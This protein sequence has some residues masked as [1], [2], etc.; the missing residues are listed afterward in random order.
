[1]IEAFLGALHADPWTAAQIDLPE[2]NQDASKTIETSI[3]ELRSCA[4]RDPSEL[5]S[6][7][8]V[9]L[10][11][12]GT[13]KTHL[14]SRVR[15]SCGPRAIFV[16]VRPLLHGGITAN[17]VLREAMRQLAQPSFGRTEWQADVLVG[18]LIARFE[19]RNSSFPGAH[20]SAFREM[21]QEL[22]QSRLEALSEKLFATFPDLDDVFVERLLALPFSAPRQ[23]RALLCWLG[24]EE[25]D[26]S[27]L[28]RI[29]AASSMAP[30]NAIRALRTLGSLAALSSPL[31][32]VFD[33]LENLIQRDATEE[34]V[35]QYGHLI[36]ELVDSTRGMLLVQ[37]ALD[38]EWEQG[39][40]PRLNAS[41]K[42]RVG[43][44][45][46]SLSLPTEAQARA[47]LAR[48]CERL[49]A[50]E[51][52]FPW[53]LTDQQ[54]EQLARL[55]GITPRM[56]LSALRE[57]REG[58][59]PTILEGARAETSEI[60]ATSDPARRTA[61]LEA[62]WHERLVVAHAQ[63]DA[64]NERRS[65]VDLS[66]LLDGV[67]LAAELSGVALRLS[68]NQYIQLESSEGEQRWFAFVNQP[69]HSSLNAALD[70]ALSRD[71]SGV[72]VRESWRPIPSSWTS[73][74]ERLAQI[75]AQSRLRWHDLTREE[76]ASFLALE[77]FLQL[78]RSR[79]LCDTDG[80]P[81]SEQE[82]AAYLR[83]EVQPEKW[84]LWEAN[85]RTDD[86]VADGATE[87][88]RPL[89]SQED[90]TARPRE[91]HHGVSLSLRSALSRLRVASVERL[92]REVRRT[93]PG[94]SRTMVVDGLAELGPEI[95]WFGRNI[96]AW[97]VQS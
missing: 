71:D 68:K 32:I 89:P 17:Y 63:I 16:H 81:I 8:L 27:Q 69:Y 12:P 73:T 39:I 22:Q 31:V 50:P 21:D 91:P 19:G 49:E 93:S 92:I 74:Q 38:S 13:G 5:R 11:P 42:S 24:G 53:P 86:A 64:A 61:A 3:A 48:W 76:V 95:R 59:V 15:K 72:L 1:M 41:Q 79:D 35:T 2:L 23:R 47:L 10:G 33:Q 85:E 57:A 94:L 54:V 30:S 9:L 46:T 25:C 82:A 55:P 84:R 7:S 58:T 66:R 87:P 56:L 51:A 26:P 36:A 52:P 75:K 20:L 96:V 80:T 77:D 67:V 44:K 34:R 28:A 43:M 70:R 78:A 45:K 6:G 14:F 4:D 83:A 90:A 65:V 37:M 62:E 97:G 60:R 29:G 18:S 88:D 40:L